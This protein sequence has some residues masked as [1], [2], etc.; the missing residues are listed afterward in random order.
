MTTARIYQHDQHQDEYC[1]GCS[2]REIYLY[3][4]FLHQHIDFVRRSSGFDVVLSRLNGVT[5]EN[6]VRVDFLAFWC[7]RGCG[8]D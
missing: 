6:I 3:L 2:D 4:L 5:N 7:V 1:E 8:Q